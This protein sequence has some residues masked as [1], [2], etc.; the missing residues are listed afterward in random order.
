MSLANLYGTNITGY[1]NEQVSD[2]VLKKIPKNTFTSVK[3]F[4]VKHFFTDGGGELQGRKIV[5]Q[6][7]EYH[8]IAFETFKVFF[9]SLFGIELDT[10]DTS[11]IESYLL[12]KDNDH[13]ASGQTAIKEV[14]KRC[15]VV[16]LY[17]SNDG[18]H[19]D[20]EIVDN[21]SVIIAKT[22]GKALQILLPVIIS[23]TS[24]SSTSK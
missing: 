24:K 4:Q 6:R 16:N 5:L 2:S 1:S 13:N 11:A 3:T 18:Q 15:M 10:I 9:L 7:T 14:F 20:S 17:I 21:K 22:C 12:G 19:V 23:T 8:Q